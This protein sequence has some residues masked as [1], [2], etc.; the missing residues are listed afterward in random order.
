MAIKID[1]SQTSLPRPID[2]YPEHSIQKI[3]VLFTDIVGSTKFFKSHGDLAGREMLQQHQDMASAAVTE[4]G[5]V[6]V[7]ILGDSAMAYFSDAKEALKAGV[8]IQQKLQTYNRT[9]DPQD[10]IH[11]R[12]AIHFGDGIIEH[13]DIFGNVVNIAAK[14][15]PLVDGDQIYISQAVYDLV[16]DLSLVRFESV[17]FSGKKDVPKGLTIYKVIWEEAVK[18]DPIAKTLVY[19]KPIWNLTEDDFG[20]IWH[21]LLAVK[22][23]LWGGKI[24]AEKIL[25]DRSVALIVKEVP[26]ALTVTKNI[27]KFIR[28]YLREDLEPLVLPIQIIIDSG[29]YVRADKLVVEELKVNWDR[30]DP[31]EI[32]ISDAAYKFI[33]NEPLFSASPQPDINQRRSFYKLISREDPGKMGPY[34]FLYQKTLIRGKNPPCYYCGGKDHLT[35]NCPSKHLPRITQALNQLGYFSFDTINRLF[36]NYIASIRSRPESGN[37]SETDTDRSTPW[38]YYGFYELKR[39]FQLRF[40][41]SIWNA[42]GD[43]WNKIKE[44]TT[45]GDKGGLVWIALDCLRVSNLARAKTLLESSLEKDPKDYRPYCATGFLNIDK[46]N[47]LGAEYHFDKALDYAKTK[48][49]KIFLLLLLSRLYD[50][51]DRPFKADEKIREILFIDPRCPE[52]IYQDVIFKFRDGKDAEALSR[53][54]KL[55]ERDRQ[56][57]VHA[58]I[59]PDLAPFSEKIHPELKTLFG[60]A[61][62]EAVQLFHKVENELNKLEKL[63]G[64]KEIEEAQSLW[65]KVK[66][67]SQADSYFAYLDMAHYSQ[68]ILAIG[69]RYIEKRRSELLDVL[70]GLNRR[71]EKYLVF[72]R[73]YRYQNLIGAAYQHL[74]LVQRKINQVRDMVNSNAPDEFKAAFAQPEKLSEELDQIEPKLKRLEMIQ[75]VILFLTRFL[76]KSLI[77]QSVIVFFAIIVFP[78]MIYYL[79]FALPKSS[80]LPADNIWAYQ[81]GILIIGG[82]FALILAIVRT[83]KSLHK[84]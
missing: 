76:K 25:S 13:N 40:F 75:H 52:A 21:H 46:N 45:E 50:V 83:I 31:G 60:Q 82:L 73:D 6:V 78:I 39:T 63:L 67:L 16:H 19:F 65:S 70:Y 64:E 49:Q 47:F 56:F 68:S 29:P 43:S 28:K 59:D 79:N 77:F 26:L 3:A 53:L 42:T 8:K 51:H 17:D 10:Q 54:I 4:H 5:G 55:I 14:L 66:K 9:R 24:E 35:L 34:L 12:I 36:F 2:E 81:K 27:I 38:A 74:M 62:D 57:Y 44:T 37:G 22:D 23:N 30:I 69:R 20:K 11:I 71:V 84:K 48:P 18:F 1:S 7:K 58:L 32:Y 72:L 80:I 33:K 15:T 41:T 61:K